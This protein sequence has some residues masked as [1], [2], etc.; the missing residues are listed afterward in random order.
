MKTKQ[1]ICLANSRKPD[2]R[3]LA[4]KEPGT[5]VWIRPISDR[6]GGSVSEE[7]RRY[8][9]GRDPKLLDVISIPLIAP[10]PSDLQPENWL[11]DPEWYWEF[12]EASDFASAGGLAD[13]PPQL[14]VNG[15]STVAGINDRI[16]ESRALPQAGSLYLVQVQ[17]LTVRVLSPGAAFGDTKRKVRG[18]FT[19]GSDEYD[20][21][22]TD[23]V[24]E[25]AFLAGAD[26]EFSI[27]DRLVTVS[28]AEP[29][30]GYAYK[31]IAALIPEA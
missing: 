9:D 1:A 29:Y 28:L 10:H 30:G 21:T 20:M 26:G 4:G 12:V 17:D 27:G 22:I 14:W 15:Y 19:Y 18:R 31:L 16:P 24:V 25:R 3:C 11:L 23:P 2:G 8:E 7:E 6:P 13:D 5:G